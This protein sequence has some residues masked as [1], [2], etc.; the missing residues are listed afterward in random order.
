LTAL[1]ELAGAQAHYGGRSILSDIDLAVANGERIALVGE[2]GAGKTTLLRLIVERCGARASY[3]PQDTGLVRALTVFHNIY[4]GRL[5]RRSTL[6]N[7][8]NLVWPARADVADVRAVA[9]RLRLEDKMFSA[10]G[11]LSGGQQQR[12]PVGRAL[13]HDGDV[14]IGDEP[15]SSVD[16]HQAREILSL[17]RDAKETTILALHDRELALAYAERIVGVREGR[18]VMDSRASDLTPSDLDFLYRT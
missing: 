13:F 9:E 8:R 7:L 2:S 17:L 6:R 18:I 12:T 14:L 16:E 3:I 10:V 4:M 1:V 15:V 11:T 5:H